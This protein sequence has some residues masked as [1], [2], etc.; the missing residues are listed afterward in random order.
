MEPSANV[1]VALADRITKQVANLSKYLEDSDIGMSDFT[2]ESR[3]RPNTGE[4]KTLHSD[5][6]SS[7]ED[8]QYLIDGPRA[9]M[10]SFICSGNDLAAFQIAFEFG[11]FN[12]VP[13]DRAIPIAELAKKAGM[14]V[15]RTARVMRMMATRR[16]FEEKTPGEFTHTAASL[17]FHEDESFRCAGHY[18]VDEMWKAA[19]ATAECVKASPY[20]SDSSHS[21]FKTRFGIPL[22][23][24]YAKNPGYA[25]RF[26]KAMAG[27]TKIDRQVTEVVDGFPWDGIRGTVVDVGGGS[28]HL[29]VSL[30]RA[31]PHLSFVVQDNS[32]SML[33]QGKDSGLRDVEGRISWMQHDFFEPQP[34]RGVSAF[35]I[36][37]CLHNWCDRDVVK[38]LEALVPALEKCDDG[39]PLLINETV[40][41]QPGTIHA[42]EERGLRQMDM[43]MLVTLGSKQR[44]KEEYETLLKEAD[45]RYE[46]YS[47]HS[48]GSMGLLE[49]HLKVER[50]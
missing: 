39:T 33:A 46:I 36:R 49:V 26:A 32:A 2:V 15:D 24:Y 35:I 45:D 38:I 40:L 14:D 48:T 19:T 12:L 18:M 6:T 37:Q 9:Y 11:F 25:A 3:E 44:T 23:E 21:P 22:F 34:L 31:F 42:P 17:V 27:A 30:A 4:F 50:S 28:G 8:L 13:T 41:P 20:E 16:T 5:L 43:L 7:L 29:S 10:R 47:L 1:L